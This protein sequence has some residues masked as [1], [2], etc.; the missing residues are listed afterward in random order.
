MDQTIENDPHT[1]FDKIPTTIHELVHHYEI[2]SD[3]IEKKVMAFSARQYCSKNFI[4][5]YLKYF[6]RFLDEKSS[7]KVLE[8]SIFMLFDQIRKLCSNSEIR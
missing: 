3:Y 2:C 4:C 8:A 7:V 5:S 1:P 6:L